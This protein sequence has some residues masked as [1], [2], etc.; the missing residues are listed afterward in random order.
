M[1][2]RFIDEQDKHI[3]SIWKGMNKRCNNKN[4]K[5]YRWYGAKGIKVCDD[6]REYLNF[7]KWAISNDFAVGLTIDRLDVSKDYSPS[8]CQWITQSENSKKRQREGKIIL[9]EYGGETRGL[10]EWSQITGINRTTLLSRI[11]SGW[12]VEKALTEKVVK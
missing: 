2:R 10:K 7:R 11:R 5:D 1:S 8:N 6:W 12:S 3:Y 4:C 9:L